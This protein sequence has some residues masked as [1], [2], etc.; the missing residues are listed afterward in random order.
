[1][2]ALAAFGLACNVMQVIEFSI[3]AARWCKEI[4]D[5]SQTASNESLDRNAHRLSETTARLSSSIEAWKGR[6]GI[7]ADEE[8]LLTHARG[9]TGIAK[10]IQEELAKLRSAGS[11]SRRGVFKKAL[12]ARW[13]AKKIENLN[14]RLQER[15][16][17]LQTMLLTNTKYALVTH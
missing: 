5:T 3:T 10:E 17:A 9:C 15:Q 12:Q 8:E 1:M 14:K 11:K 16:T 6:R 7:E 13:N 2:E 4:Y